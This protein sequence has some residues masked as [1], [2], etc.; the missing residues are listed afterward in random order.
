MLH[1][2]SLLGLRAR[3]AR[4]RAQ[5][6]KMLTVWWFF[7]VLRTTADSTMVFDDFHLWGSLG[8]LLGP[9]W[10]ILGVSWCLLGPPWDPLGVALCHLGYLFVLLGPILGQL[11][12][13]WTPLGVLW[14]LIAACLGLSWV[15]FGTILGQQPHL[16]ASSL[17]S[18]LRPA[19]T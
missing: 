3:P 13:S 7:I 15:I 10:A 6:Q 14:A 17:R 9:P 12:S 18:D 4:L 11:G 19:F 8:T 2:L 16:C 5:C 1:F